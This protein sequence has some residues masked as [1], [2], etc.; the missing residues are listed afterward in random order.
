MRLIEV[1]V[2]D[3]GQLDKGPSQ[4]VFTSHLYAFRSLGLVRHKM[5]FT[6][7]AN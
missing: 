2:P 3:V 5:R 1:V 4:Q 7:A 6:R